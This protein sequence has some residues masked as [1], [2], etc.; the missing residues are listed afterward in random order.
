M[1]DQHTPQ[2]PATS[3]RRGRRPGPLPRGHR[4][5]HAVDWARL[6]ESVDIACEVRGCSMRDVAAAIGVAPSSLTR[7]RQG[8]ALAADGLA[9]LVAWLYPASAPTWIK[10]AR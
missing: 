4:T 10:E 5:S 6:I 2:P 8:Q 1:T 7:M 3:P 9:S